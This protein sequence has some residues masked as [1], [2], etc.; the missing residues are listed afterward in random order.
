MSYIPFPDISPEI[1]TISLFG[2]DFALR[3]YALGY[4]VGLLGGWRIVMALMR[5][6]ALW[7]DNR[8]PMQPGRVEDLLTWV[9][10]GVILGGRLGFVLFYQPAHYLANPG[11]ILKVWQGGMAFHGGFLGVVIAAWVWAG[12]NAVPRAQLA[13]A[14]A[15]AAPLGLGL[16]RIANFINAELWGHPTTMPWG[17]AFPGEGAICDG[18]IGICARH[19]SQ[20][21]EAALEG[22]VLGLALAFLALRRGWLKH[23]GRIAGLFI[24]GYGI[25]RFMVEFFRVPDLFEPGTLLALIGMSKGQAYSLPMV[26]VGL[27]L[28]WRARRASA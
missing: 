3:W 5:R 10:I 18:V 15:L 14:L 23:P 25:A 26:A 27:W 17:V 19:P 4:V 21:Y 13:D 9:I 1:F 16:V 6:P 12:R 20:L 24:A 11:D 2:L 7:P 8:A 22:L 28:I